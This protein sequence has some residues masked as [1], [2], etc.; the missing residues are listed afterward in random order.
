MEYKPLSSQ[1]PMKKQYILQLVCLFGL[2]SCDYADSRLM[3]Y[4]AT[5]K[6]YWGA[7]DTDDELDELNLFSNTKVATRSS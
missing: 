5:D 2:L 3:I 1:L 4:N 7:Y 6:R